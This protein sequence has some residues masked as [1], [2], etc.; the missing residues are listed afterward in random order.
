M[1]LRSN[2]PASGE[3][4][5]DQRDN[6]QHEQDVDEAAQCI[7]AND[8]KE[9]KHKKN[10]KNGP[11]HKHPSGVLLW[12]GEFRGGVVRDCKLLKSMHLGRHDQGIGKGRRFCLTLAFGAVT[13]VGLELVFASSG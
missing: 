3:K 2:S 5:E 8:S 9:P 12:E 1:K 4:L 11:Q 13:L 6:S 10:H 7:T